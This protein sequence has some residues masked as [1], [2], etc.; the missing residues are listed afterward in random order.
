VPCLDLL[1][2]FDDGQAAR[3]GQQHRTVKHCKQMPI[4]TYRSGGCAGWANGCA[5]P[6]ARNGGSSKEIRPVPCGVATSLTYGA[7][8]CGDVGGPIQERTTTATIPGI[9]LT[10]KRQAPAGSEAP[11]LASPRWWTRRALSSTDESSDCSGVSM[12]QRWPTQGLCRPKRRMSSK[13]KQR[14]DKSE[15]VFI[16]TGG[17]QPRRVPDRQCL[18]EVRARRVLAKEHRCELDGAIAIQPT[19]AEATP[20]L[21]SAVGND[22][23]GRS[24]GTGTTS[25]CDR[26]MRRLRCK[27]E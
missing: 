20:E 11:A 21:R 22:W 17:Q 18:K 3:G 6:I 10:K 13:H 23:A 9:G 12:L 8:W 14:F 27:G 2:A 7:P 5:R 16:G 15:P 24:N 26:Y 25:Q 4:S 19:V 1:E